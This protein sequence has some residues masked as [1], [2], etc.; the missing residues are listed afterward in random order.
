MART[1]LADTWRYIE[2]LR[3]TQTIRD[4]EDILLRVAGRFGLISAFGGVV[5]SSLRSPQ[6]VIDLVLVQRFPVGWSQRYEVKRYLLRDP[7]LR[8][9]QA[10]SRS[11][12]S[13]KD[14]YATAPRADTLAVGGEASE[15]GLKD[16]IVIPVDTL[17]HAPIAVSFGGAQVDLGRDDVAALRFATN[18]AVGQILY[19]RAAAVDSVSDLTQRELDCLRWA[20]EGKSDWEVGRILGI[21]PATVEKHNLSLRVKLGAV[22]RGHA[23][24][25][26]LRL[27]VID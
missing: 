1:P 18:Y 15:F 3:R 6:D 27:K 9:L 2:D 26:A 8:R 13:W 21:S 20:A 12:F 17:D 7:I 24:A 16:G 25:K 10:D 11:T 19:H 22:N 14:A 23:I 5:P 4:V